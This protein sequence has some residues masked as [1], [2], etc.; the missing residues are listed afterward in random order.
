MILIKIDDS[1]KAFNHP[2]E[3][4]RVLRVVADKLDDLQSEGDIRAANC[5][6][7]GRFEVV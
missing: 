1:H 4:G 2:Y 5:D 7:V 3:S 6:L